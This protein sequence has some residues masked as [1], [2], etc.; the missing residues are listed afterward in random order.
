MAIIGNI[1]PTFSDK[2][3]WGILNIAEPKSPEVSIPKQL[4]NDLDDVRIPKFEKPPNVAVLSLQ[5]VLNHL[6][7]GIQNQ[8]TIDPMQKTK[9]VW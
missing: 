3:K 4:S 7:A 5:D 1:N 2:P 8:D 6:L 9:N